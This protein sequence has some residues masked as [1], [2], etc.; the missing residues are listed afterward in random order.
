[1]LL[2]T[3]IHDS[4]SLSSC[5]GMP[6]LR[7]VQLPGRLCTLGKNRSFQD[8][9]LALMEPILFMKSTYLVTFSGVVVNFTSG[10]LSIFWMSSRL[11]LSFEI[12]R[13]A[14]AAHFLSLLI[15][16]IASSSALVNAA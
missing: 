1:M 6:V 10:S 3:H 16:P 14:S 7:A 11:S 13:Y 4:P 8:A 9:G 2:G 12:R 15:M 5:C